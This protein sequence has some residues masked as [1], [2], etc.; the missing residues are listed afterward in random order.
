[1]AEGRWLKAD[2]SWAK[3]KEGVLHDEYGAIPVKKGFDKYA[4][5]DFGLTP[6]SG[7][8]PSLHANWETSATGKVSQT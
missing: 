1:M 5:G 6:H 3:D 4:L 2:G 8:L 7:K